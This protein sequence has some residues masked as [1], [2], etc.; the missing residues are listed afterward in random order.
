MEL[1]ITL[2]A[3]EEA[4]AATIPLNEG[5]TREQAI[6]RTLHHEALHPIVER[7]QREKRETAALLLRQQWELLTPEHKLEVEAFTRAKI[8]AQATVA[9][10]DVTP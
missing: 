1:V 7:Y 10:A 9:K 6:V 4:A 2:S 8:A 3:D 5:E